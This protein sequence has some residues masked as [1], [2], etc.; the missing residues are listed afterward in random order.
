[1]GGGTKQQMPRVGGSE[2]PPQ[3]GGNAVRDNASKLILADSATSIRKHRID[4]HFQNMV[5]GALHSITLRPG[6]WGWDLGQDSSGILISGPNGAPVALNQFAL[7]PAYVWVEPTGPTR[8][9]DLQIFLRTDRD[10]VLGTVTLPTGA[11]LSVRSDYD[12]VNVFGRSSW[13]VLLREIKQV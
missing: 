11:T 10:H 6:P 1:M 8:A 7:G 2:Q 13:G 4:M 3:P 12:R 9:I 5:A